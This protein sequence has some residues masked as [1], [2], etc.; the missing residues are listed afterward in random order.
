MKSSS[1]AA[2]A[3][4]A[5]TASWMVGSAGCASD[6]D[7]SLAGKQCDAAG[8]C[9]AGYVCDHA[10]NTCV[11]PEMLTGSS[12]WMNERLCPLLCRAVPT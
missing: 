5:L 10:S 11:T 8:Q 2:A 7:G 12:F 1:F 6:L 9:V 4:A 3:L